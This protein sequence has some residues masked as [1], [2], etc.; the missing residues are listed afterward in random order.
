MQVNSINLTNFSGKVVRHETW[1]KNNPNARKELSKKDVDKTYEKA[2]KE[3]QQ[4]HDRA[5]ELDEFMNSKKVREEVAK[6]PD[7]VNIQINNLYNQRYFEKPDSCYGHK[8][9]VQDINAI[10]DNEFNHGREIDNR[11]ATNMACIRAQKEDGTIN[12][13]YIMSW[14]KSLQEY[15]NEDKPM[16]KFTS[17]IIK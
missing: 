2:M 15:F 16:D 4:Q 17:R 8:V 14:I 10:Y 6:L 12:K 9:S 7:N 5:V 11:H 13:K 3:I 1:K